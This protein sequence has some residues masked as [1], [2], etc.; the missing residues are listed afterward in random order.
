MPHRLATWLLWIGIV[1]SIAREVGHGDE[2]VRLL[3]KLQ[4][5]G[6]GHAGFSR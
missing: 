5:R 6:R 1:L 2:L 3:G 4:F